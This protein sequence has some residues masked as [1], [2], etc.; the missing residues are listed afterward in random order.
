MFSSVWDL[1]ARKSPSA[2][3]L[4]CQ[5]IPQRWLGNGSNVRL[6][7]Y[8][9]SI[10][11]IDYALNIRLF[12]YALNIRLIDDGPLS[13]FRGRLSSASSFHVS[14]LQTIDGVMSLAL[15]PQVKSQVLQHFKSSETK[16]TCEGCFP[17]SL[18]A[19]S[20]PFTL[21]CPGHYTHWSF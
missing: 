8:A 2:L 10:R 14:F 17:V 16:T 6:F 7:D 13:S 4:I 3:H 12:D 20:F 15:G 11:L 9:L 21:A 18:S 5:K 19:R 1:C